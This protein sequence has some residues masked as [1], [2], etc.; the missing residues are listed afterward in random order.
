MPGY[1]SAD[2]PSDLHFNP[3]SR[4]FAFERSFD[5]SP[6]I[7]SIRHRSPSP[8]DLKR[9]YELVESLRPQI[10]HP[11]EVKPGEVA[12]LQD[13]IIPVDL[14][15]HGPSTEQDTRG[16]S[17]SINVGKS[18]GHGRAGEVPQILMLHHMAV[19]S[20]I[21]D[22]AGA[23]THASHST[24][25]SEKGISV[26]NDDSA[27]MFRNSLN[28]GLYLDR[29]VSTPEKLTTQL[30]VCMPVLITYMSVLQRLLCYPWYSTRFD[31]VAGVDESYRTALSLLGHTRQPEQIVGMIRTVNEIGNIGNQNSSQP[32]VHGTVYALWKT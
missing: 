14:V 15:T 6:D 1:E 26:A 27:V 16:W 31:T 2:F 25:F 29:P 3:F 8:D 32:G 12:A 7:G 5:Y 20:A 19:A 18:Y 9:L 13:P 10:D 11:V 21:Y 30:A 4:R 28:A 24:S 17:A 23:P 22:H